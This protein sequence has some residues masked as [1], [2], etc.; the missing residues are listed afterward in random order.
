MKFVYLLCAAAMLPACSPK[1]RT[2]PDVKAPEGAAVVAR[3][4]YLADNVLGC[5]ECHSKRDWSQPGAPVIPGTEFGGGGLV[6]DEHLR[7]N[8]APFPGRIQP[9][10]IS[11]SADDGIG[12]WSDGEILRAIREG[13]NKEGDAMFPFMPY[14]NF[15][16]LADADALA[17]VAY[18]R[19]IPP[20][21]GKTAPTDLNFPMNFIVNTI[22][23]PLDRPVAGPATD[24][25]SRGRYL[26][27]NGGCQDCHSPQNKGE[28]VAGQEFSGGV[29]IEAAKYKEIG[30]VVS[31]NLTPDADTG[32]GKV[33]R[34]QFVLML[35]EGKGKDGRPLNPVMPWYYLR[36]QSDEDLGAMWAYLQTLAPVKKDA[37]KELETYVRAE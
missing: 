1:F 6:F 22:P 34:E 19:T 11:Q 5:L 35:R 12:A 33:T 36:A 23:A 14:V 8:G 21:A 18:L 16:H 26:V 4:K 17:V 31:S 9:P 13:V 29:V 25:V 24:A 20:R 10:N 28:P 7:M 30:T 3:G 27:T 2:A 32:L 15:K 37:F